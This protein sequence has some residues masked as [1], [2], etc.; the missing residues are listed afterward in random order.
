MHDGG[1]AEIARRYYEVY[2]AVDREGMEALLADDFTFTSPWDDHI[3]RATYFS[4]CWP[5]AGEFRFRLPMKVFVQGDEAVAVYETE[6]KQG[7]T[8]HNAELLR[9][10]S[11]R[12]RSIDVFFGFIPGARDTKAAAEEAG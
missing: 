11:G 2:Q 8:F 12:I 3:D 9:F 5:H 4:H 10:A 7:G 6:G 1:I